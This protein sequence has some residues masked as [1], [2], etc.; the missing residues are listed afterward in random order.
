MKKL[1]LLIFILIQQNINSQTQ[2]K[3]NSVE[4]Y[5]LIRS[6]EKI[7]D[8]ENPIIELKINN[9]ILRFYDSGKIYFR[10]NRGQINI[11]DLYQN[12][13]L[14]EISIN[15]LKILNLNKSGFPE[16]LFYTTEFQSVRFWETFE[17][18]AIVINF[19]D[20]IVLW[21]LPCEYR[22]INEE[23]NEKNHWIQNIFITDNKLKVEN[24]KGNPNS[25]DIKGIR[26][27]IYIYRNGKFS[28]QY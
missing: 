11:Y 10:N 8:S 2:I 23:S 25:A 5:K 24:N 26:Q 9:S 4:P 20:E 12:N 16:I 13:L 17:K 22:Y 7:E 15:N 28:L 19:D 14:S 6:N 1:L 18:H 3:N 21:N 27:G